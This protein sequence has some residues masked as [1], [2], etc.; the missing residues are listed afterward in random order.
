MHASTGRFD[1][2][3]PSEE[4]PHTQLYRGFNATIEY[5]D[6][7]DNIDN[8]RV[9]LMNDVVK[10][11]EISDKLLDMN[12]NSYFNY[13]EIFRLIGKN[14][15]RESKPASVAGQLDSLRRANQARLNYERANNIKYQWIVRLRM[16][17]VMKTNIWE[18]LFLIEP[19][20]IS[21]P[22][23]RNLLDQS[24]IQSTKSMA[25]F[26]NA[27]WNGGLLYDMVYTPS[28]CFHISILLRTKEDLLLLNLQ[29]LYL[30]NEPNSRF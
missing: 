20:N 4:H 16:D 12:I 7:Y 14:H 30:Q 25:N 15:D 11:V 5:Y 28:K 17:H 21:N 23:H 27:Y 13:T 6:A 18:D 2:K 10:Y 22:Y 26:T 24:S 9:S 8:E 29:H 3:T 19:L 1:W